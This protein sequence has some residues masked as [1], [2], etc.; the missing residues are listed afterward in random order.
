M[1]LLWG[2]DISIRELIGVCFLY[3]ILIIYII[4]CFMLAHLKQYISVIEKSEN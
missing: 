2:C 1:F 3:Y 4:Q